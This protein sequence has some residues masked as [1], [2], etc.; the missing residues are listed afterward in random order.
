MH[1]FAVCRLRLQVLEKFRSDLVVLPTK[2]RDMA[3]C[4]VECSNADEKTRQLSSIAA[5]VLG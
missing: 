3:S 2:P 4:L 5:D 1:K